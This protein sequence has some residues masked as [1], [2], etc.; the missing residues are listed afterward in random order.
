MELWAREIAYEFGG[1]EMAG[2]GI[3]EGSS[4]R[5]F[6][7]DDNENVPYNIEQIFTLHHTACHLVTFAFWTNFSLYTILHG[8]EHFLIPNE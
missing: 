6:L 2:K 1:R 4:D 5:G 3:Q 7:T 8:R